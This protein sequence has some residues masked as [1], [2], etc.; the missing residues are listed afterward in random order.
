MRAAARVIAPGVRSAIRSSTERADELGERGSRRLG[1]V[2]PAF[3]LPRREMHLKASACTTHAGAV[4]RHYLQTYYPLYSIPT[5]GAC[6]EYAAAQQGLGP[7]PGLHEAPAVAQCVADGWGP[8]TEA[9]A[10]HAKGGDRA[11][12]FGTRT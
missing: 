4:T 8:G 2:L 6:S 9:R 11:A 1:R 12:S 3:V 5:P 7:Q 10:S